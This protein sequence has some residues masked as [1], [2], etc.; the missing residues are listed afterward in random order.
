MLF[1]RD[2][3]GMDDAILHLLC[4]PEL[5]WRLGDAALARVFRDFTWEKHAERILEA[6]A[7]SAAQMRSAPELV[8][9]SGTRE[10]AA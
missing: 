5:A 4:Q 2:G 9:M 1:A 7:G 8:S 6:V 10:R 3:S